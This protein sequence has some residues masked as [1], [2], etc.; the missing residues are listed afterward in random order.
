[1]SGACECDTERDARHE[2]EK[3][4]PSHKTARETDAF[5][6]R[7]MRHEVKNG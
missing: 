7:F 4:L 1:M 6:N 2:V 3:E 5:A